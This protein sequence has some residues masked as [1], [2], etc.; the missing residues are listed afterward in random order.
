MNLFTHE[1]RLH[2]DPS[3]VVVRPFHIAWGGVGGPPNRTE[4]LVAEVLAMTPGQARE[5]LEEVLKDFEARHWQTRRVFMTRYDEIEG[6][7]G[8]DSEQIGDE[9][10]QLIGA[11]FC[12]EYSYAAA[13]LMNPS[14]VPHFDQSGMPPGSLRVLM[15][16]RAVGEGHISSVA[17]R[18]GI[19]T[20]RNQMK[21]APEPPFATATDA[22]GRELEEALEGPITVYR[23]RDSTLSGTVIFP[24]T[25]AQSKGLEDMRIVQFQHED[26]SLEWIGTYTAYNG[27]QIQSE[28]MR[29]RDFRAFDLVPMT[30][31]ASH[32]KGMAL[33]PRKVD[34]RYMMIGRSDG[35]NLFLLKSD[36]LTH[37][38]NGEKILTPVYPWELV[39]IGNCG[40]PIE[41]DEGWLLLTHGVGAMRKYSIG[42]VLLDKRD[43][44]KVIGRTKEPLL[45]A[46]DQDREG[47]VPNVVYSC[48]AIRH[49]DTLFL[50]YGIA[51]SSIGFAF[52]GI[53]DLLAAMA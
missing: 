19:I 37:W 49:G 52:V 42:A 47:Y 22:T 29:T 6:L 33:F 40:P 13:A 9:K 28:L 48:G 1:L 23:H 4:R 5:Q 7:L 16:M 30:G 3:R 27:S 35:E 43:P 53:R 21:L 24:M 20:D 17:F 8:L 11:Y 38:D 32:N 10:R 14:A 2:A 46:K 31:T 15:S 39:Q 25:A 18:E 26:G 45:A 36:D 51:D 44:A 41:L 34:G 12:H 50:P